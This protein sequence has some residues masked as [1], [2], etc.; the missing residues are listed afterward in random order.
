MG[1]RAAL[2]GLVGLLLLL[3][4]PPTAAALPVTAGALHY[5]APSAAA[6]ADVVFGLRIAWDAT[7][8]GGAVDP[9]ALPDLFNGSGVTLHF[10]DG[11]RAVF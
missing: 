1:P 10:G 4:G 6:P 8:W 2:A 11:A 9:G 3:A 7:D 5:W